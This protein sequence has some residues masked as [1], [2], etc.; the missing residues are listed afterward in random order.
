[1][2]EPTQSLGRPSIQVKAELEGPT[3]S[4]STQSL[5][6]VLL[7]R[8]RLTIPAWAEVEGA[9]RSQSTHSPGRPTMQV[10]AEHEGPF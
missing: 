2:T 4:R 8:T 1:M 5:G 6:R 3:R 7:T 9:A 10:K